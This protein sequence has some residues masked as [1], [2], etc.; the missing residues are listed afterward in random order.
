MRLASWAVNRQSM[1]APAAFRSDTP[2]LTALSR[3]SSSPLRP[4]RQAR[5]TTLN[6]ISAI[7]SAS[8]G[9]DSASFRAWECGG[10]PAVWQYAGLGRREGLV[11]RHHPMSVHIIE[12]QPNHRD[13]VVGL[14]HSH[15]LRCAKSCMVPCL[16]IAM[17]RQPRRGS[18]ATPIP[19]WD[20]H[21]RG[22]DEDRKDSSV[23]H[24]T[25]GHHP[26]QRQRCCLV[27]CTF[28]LGFSL[29]RIHRWEA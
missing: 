12:N 7:P 11:K 22:L 9:Q 4:L 27:I 18:P 13:T 8:S 1:L 25:F 20:V 3:L 17:W 16:D 5:A 6:S 19:R 26:G 21:F 10:T 15:R 28:H 29:A 14:I 23:P 24:I 2:A